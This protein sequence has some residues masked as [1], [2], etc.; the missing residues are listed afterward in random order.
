MSIFNRNKNTPSMQDDDMTQDMSGDDLGGAE[1]FSED[2]GLSAPVSGRTSSGGSRRGLLLSLL[3]ILGLAGGGGYFYLSSQSDLAAL[4][5]PAGDGMMPVAPV[6]GTPPADMVGAPALDANGMPIAT[7]PNMIAA[8]PNAMPPMPDSAQAGVTIDPATGLAVDPNAQMPAADQMAPSA[9]DPTAPPADT[10]VVDPAAIPPTDP[11]ADPMAQPVDPMAQTAPVDPMAQTAPVDPT[12][13]ADPNAEVAVVDPNAPTAIEPAIMPQDAMQDP[14]MAINDPSGL[15]QPSNEQPPAD[16][17]M[18]AADVTAAPAD[19][20]A[21]AP[22]DATAPSTDATAVPAAAETATTTDAATTTDPATA[23]TTT[24]AT[25]APVDGGVTQTAA[26]ANPYAPEPADALIRPLPNQYLEVKKE[27]SSDTLDARLATARRALNEGR[28]AAALSFFEDLSRDFP[29]DRRVLMGRALAMQK[30]GQ[31]REALAAYEDV[32]RVDPKNLDAVTNMLGLLKQQNPQLAID[33]LGELRAAYPFN[34]TI[35]TQ[36]AIAHGSAGNNAEALRY[37]T[38]AEG[39]KPG[40]TTLMYNKAVLL[41]KM[42]RS[43]EAAD[44]YRALIRMSSEGRLQQPLPVE[45]M[46]QRLSTLR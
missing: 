24:D 40:D 41:D 34:H 25:T 31:S 45:Q 4:T 27:Q 12:M 13:P 26:P 23:T 37:L 1:E 3:V 17:M 10:A 7:D 39:L 20:A 38:L 46:R 19:A 30:L 9:I 6:D 2:E 29:S 21:T 5:P 32:L 8:D 11:A 42:G 43:R 36:L 44:L 14:N 16:A 15:A 22:V 35:T 28:S 33:K 18:P